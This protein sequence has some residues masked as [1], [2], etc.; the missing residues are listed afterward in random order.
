MTEAE[1]IKSFQYEG[2]DIS[3]YANNIQIVDSDD[4]KLIDKDKKAIVTT[5]TFSCANILVYNKNFAFLVHMFPSETVGK[6]NKFDTR[7]EYLKKLFLEKQVSEVNVM[8]SLGASIDYE[9]NMNFH[10]LDHINNKL[11]GL[12]D[13]C[14]DNN[15]VLNMLPTIRSKYLLFDLEKQLLIVDN[16][17]KKAI[18]INK[19]ELLKNQLT[20]FSS[21]KSK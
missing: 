12:A 5:S 8:V 10:N 9:K 6:N 3:S 16:E 1:I 20:N 14:Q 2:F 17:E 18:E 7:V 21:K 15:I 11:N 13:F 19:L 4:C